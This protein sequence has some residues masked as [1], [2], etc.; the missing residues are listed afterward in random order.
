MALYPRFFANQFY[1]IKDMVFAS[2]YMVSMWATVEAIHSKLKVRWLVVFSVLAA[3]ATNVRIVGIIFPVFFIGYIILTWIINKCGIEIQDKYGHPFRSIFVISIAYL[4]S[5]IAML[6]MLWKNPISGIFEIFEKFSQYD[7]W[8]G[9]VVFMGQFVRGS[10][11]PWYYVPVWLLVSVPIWYWILLLFVVAL[12]GYA[13]YKWIKGHKRISWS[14]LFEYKYL[15]WMFF[16]ALG[17]WLA[18]VIFH[19]TLYNAWRHCFFLLPPIVLMIIYG[20]ALIKKKIGIGKITKEI[21]TGIVIIGLASQSIWMIKNHPY[22]MVYLNEVGRIWGDQFDRDY[23]CLA[24]TDMCRY[25]LENDSSEKISVNAPFNNFERLLNKEE[26]NR[27]VVEED[28]TYW[29]ESYRK[30]KGNEYVR[31]GYTEI[32]YITVDGYKIGSVQKKIE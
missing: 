10:E 19:S 23:W 13:F 31:E 25:V 24:T 29:L 16:L 1:D 26:K 6:P 14:C 17:P 7:D 8:N 2:M 21:L 4:G 28:P 30:V 3:M 11:V 12:F 27:I 32:Y 22:Q 18:T 5:Y 15:I 9:Y 20:L